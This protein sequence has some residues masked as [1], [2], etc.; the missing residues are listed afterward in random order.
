MMKI[1]MCTIQRHTKHN[2]KACNKN[3]TWS[4]A[5]SC[6]LIYAQAPARASKMADQCA[7]TTATQIL[8]L[9]K[10]AVLQKKQQQQHVLN[11]TIAADAGEGGY[12]EVHTNI[13]RYSKYYV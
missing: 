13:S 3:T 10:E 8:Y 12:L 4:R 6:E 7:N 5:M 11:Q 9:R 1:W 2:G